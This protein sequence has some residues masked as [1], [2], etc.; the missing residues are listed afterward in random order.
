MPEPA[1]DPAVAFDALADPTRRSILRVLAD[2]GELRVGDLAAEVNQVGRTA[3][4]SHLRILRSAG[5]VSERRDGRYRLYSVV[6]EPLDDVVQF[7]GSLYRSPL[8]DLKDR[9]DSAREPK[10]GEND[11]Q[12]GLQQ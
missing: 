5:L 6:G 2:R 12:P 3:V 7:L 9:N 1:A 10:D 11:R 8:Q 4:S